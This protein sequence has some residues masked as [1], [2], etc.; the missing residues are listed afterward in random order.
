MRGWSGWPRFVYS[1]NPINTMD[2][3]N[4]TDETDL[5][6]INNLGTLDLLQR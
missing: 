1:L 5:S 6:L 2:F 4:Q 3:S